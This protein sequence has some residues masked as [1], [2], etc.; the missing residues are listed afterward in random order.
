VDTRKPLGLAAMKSVALHVD[1]KAMQNLFGMV[2]G[3]VADA[4]LHDREIALLSTWLAEHEGLAGTWPGS[5]IASNVRAVLADGVITEEE[6][7]HL[8]AV[9]SE[10]ANTNF[11]ATGSATAEP[12]SLPIEADPSPFSWLD[13]GVVHT[14]TFLYGTRAKC[15]R[16]TMA[17]GGMPLDSVSRST[18]VLVIGTRV[19]PS[20]ANESYGRKILKA[21]EMRDAGHP[22][23]IVS[24]A[25]WFDCARNG[26]KAE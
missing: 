26:G 11:A 21:V 1:N 8:L 19:T 24:E 6:R 4:H 20:W 2:T 17:L 13:M 22:V 14:G 3:I 15:E 5:V 12:I 7:A 18:D 25:Y 23:R 10:L 9:L 16:L